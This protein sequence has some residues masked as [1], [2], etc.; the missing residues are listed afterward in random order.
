MHRLLQGEVGSGKTVVALR[1]M[2]QVVDAGGQAALLAPTEVLAAQHARSHRGDC[3]ARSAGPAS[4]AAPTTAT[5]VALLT[6]SLPAAGPP[7]GA[8]RR[9]L[10][11][12]PGI[13]VGTHALLQEQRRSSPTSAWSWSTSSTG[14]ASSSATRCAPRPARPPHVLVMTATPDPAHGRD[15]RL[16]RPGDLDADRAA[17][18]A[19]R[20]SA[21]TVVPA[22]EKP[23]WLERAWQRIREEVGAG[24][25]GLRGLPA[26]R[27]RRRAEGETDGRADADDGRRRRAGG[28]R[29][30]C[31]SVAADA[32]ATARWPACG[33]ACCTAGCRP[34]EKDAGDARRSPPARSTCW[35][36]PRSSRSA[37]TCPTPP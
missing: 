20:R 23:A 16:R 18:R 24:P 37:S 26:D 35:S 5:R 9:R 14:S 11:R 8:A 28:R 25:P 34:T 10:R 6:G 12:R 22:A 31:S 36:R 3:S 21:R 1:A 30:R 29:S 27:R 2:L 19:G 15:D 33:S 13:V 17:R 32:R 7:R 4:W